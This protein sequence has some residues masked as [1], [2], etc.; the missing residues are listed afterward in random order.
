M[1]NH[2]FW[3]V[4][5]LYM[6]MFNSFFYVYQAG[7]Q[8]FHRHRESTGESRHDV[9]APGRPHPPLPRRW[10]AL[11][12]RENQNVTGMECDISIYISYMI[13]IYHIYICISYMINIYIIYIYYI[14]GWWF[15]TWLLF[16]HNT[17]D[18]PSHW[19][20]HIFQRVGQP[21]TRLYIYDMK[22]HSWWWNV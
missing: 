13:N 2:H 5:P 1:E 16:S 17:W 10:E 6:A 9:T 21:P 20:T 4:N 19:R 3:W 12:L 18:N 15:Q 11:S 22:N 14:S 8:R 7:S